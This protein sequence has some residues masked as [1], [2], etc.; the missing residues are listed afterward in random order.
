MMRLSIVFAVPILLASSAA[1]AG[2]ATHGK[3]IFA[4]TCANCHSTEIGVNKVG[5]SLFDIV[6]RPTASLPDFTYSKALRDL[7]GTQPRWSEAAIDSYLSN[8][9]EEVHGVKMFF[10]GLPEAKDRNDVIAYLKTLN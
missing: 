1:W 4:H 6:G 9:R 7:G 10:K 3:A 5:P 2:D 8:P